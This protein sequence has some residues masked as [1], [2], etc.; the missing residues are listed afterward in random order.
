MN[1]TMK[2]FGI[3]DAAARIGIS[4]TALKKRWSKGQ[5]PLPDAMYNDHRPLWLPETLDRFKL[6]REKRQ[7]EQ[8][9][10]AKTYRSNGA[11]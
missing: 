3:A 1:E 6:D 10:H 11:L 7:E 5:A 8:T 9:R 2:Y 4:H